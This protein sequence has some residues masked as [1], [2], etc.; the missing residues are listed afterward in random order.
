M[1]RERRRGGS[2]PRGGN[3]AN[4]GRLAAARALLASEEGRFVD[5]ELARRAPES[6]PDR[7]LAWFLALGTLRRRGHVDAALRPHLKQPLAS[8]DAPVRVVLRMAAFE[9]LF[10]RAGDHAVV[11]QAVELTRALKAGRASGLVNAVLRKV[12]MPTELSRADALDHPSWLVA[13]WDKRYGT[14][15]TEAW[16]AANAEEPPLVLVARD[17]PEKLAEALT[18]LGLTVRPA[19]AGGRDVPGALRVEGHTGTIE[20]LPGYDDGAF[21]V[22]DASATATADLVGATAGMR[23]LDTCAAP[24][25]KT[26]RLLSQGAEVVATDREARRLPRLRDSL[27]RTGMRAEVDVHDWVVAPREGQF[28]AVIVDAPCTGLGT[29]RRSPEIRWSRVFRDVLA[30]STKQL[31]ILANA[32]TNVKP[33]GVLV[34]AVCS[35]EPEEGRILVKRFLA[36]H[37]EFTV[38]TELDTAPPEDD[39]DGFYAV[40]MVRA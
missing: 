28:D 34:Y 9:K 29:I 19:R 36:D 17:E 21:W 8:L 31:A 24:G 13:R 26:L 4:P 25:G 27:R 30:A 5:E 2:P 32:A 35:S 14:E 16:C 39:E 37:A 11:D 1:S 10:G 22:Q 18:A 20:T 6:G 23:V 38:E 33:G 12:E 3:R 7:G 40:R 15:A